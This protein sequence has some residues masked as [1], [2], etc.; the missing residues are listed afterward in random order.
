MSTT[1]THPPNTTET[2]AA[3][4]AG[5]E[6]LS[7]EELMKRYGYVLTPEMLDWVGGVTH[8]LTKCVLNTWIWFNLKPQILGRENI[9]PYP[10]G[11]L[12]ITANHSTLKDIPMVSSVMG[13]RPIAYI[14]K[15]ELSRTLLGRWFFRCAR[16]IP[17]NR[18]KPDLSTFRSA[19][20]VLADP[21]WSLGIFPEGTRNKDGSMGEA[22]K[23]AAHIA[24]SNK[25]DIL[26]IAIDWCAHHPKYV[27]V[28]IGKVIHSQAF[29][30]TEELH[31]HLSTTLM[32]LKQE[33]M[34]RHQQTCQS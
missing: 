31:Q 11:P 28:N 1:T 22:K 7:P 17:I 24:K 8:F 16:V 10:S 32:Q 33:A 25:A 15:I 23:G 19:K 34:V 12:V 3:Q 20:N 29:E 13:F 26:P 21:K 30:T 9:P 18:Q 5:A 14:A 27:T 4:I 6:K 2:E